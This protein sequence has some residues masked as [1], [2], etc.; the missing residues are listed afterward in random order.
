LEAI[1]DISNDRYA[2]TFRV[3]FLDSERWND[4]LSETS[5][6]RNIPYDFINNVDRTWDRFLLYLKV[7]IIVL[8][9]IKVSILRLLSASTNYTASHSRRHSLL[10]RVSKPLTRNVKCSRKVW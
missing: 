9:H 6:E 3:K 8:L 10:V 4:C 7:Q 5:T 2:F 1:S